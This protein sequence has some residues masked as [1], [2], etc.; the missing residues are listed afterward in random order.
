MKNI[1]RIKLSKEI[2]DTILH[3][4]CV[5]RSGM[6]L[7]TYLEQHG[8]KELAHQLIDRC[9]VHDISKL[10]DTREFAALASIID[11]SEDPLL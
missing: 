2:Y 4:K 1:D 6:Y 3:R 9:L 11:Q 10:E 7:A 8:D 5:L